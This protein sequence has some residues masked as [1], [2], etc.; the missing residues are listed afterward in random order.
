L[1]EKIQRVSLDIVDAIVV[2]VTSVD[3]GG[4]PE[5]DRKKGVKVNELIVEA[6]RNI[7]RILLRAEEKRR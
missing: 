6:E 1:E 2:F 4:G 3:D 7:G 5:C